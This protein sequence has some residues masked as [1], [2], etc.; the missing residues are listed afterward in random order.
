MIIAN[1]IYDVAFKFLMED[2]ASAKVMLSALLQRKVDKV[3][4]RNQEYS[5]SVSKDL[6]LYRLDFSAYVKNNT[7]TTDVIH[8]ELQKKWLRSEVLRF[9]RYL[10]VQYSDERNISTLPGHEGF[11]LSTV[12]IYIL[13]HA[14]DDLPFPIVYVK[15]QCLDHNSNAC[16][17]ETPSKFVDSISHD[18][19]IVQVPLLASK[20][21]THLE[22]LMSIFHS[23]PEREIE[24]DDKLASSDVEVELV[25]KRLQLVLSDPERRRNL[26]IEQEML[27]DLMDKDDEL[28]KKDEKLREK[29]KMLRDKD[30]ML[31]D[32]DEMLRDRDDA[33]VLKDEKLRQQDN[34]LK[35]QDE[36]MKAQDEKMKEQSDTL[37][38]LVKM[39]VSLGKSDEEI[40]SV[41]H[42]SIS[43]VE[44][45]RSAI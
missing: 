14:L 43:V 32:K 17:L 25:A 20:T 35:I 30:K 8:I 27:A 1:A 12:A 45:I 21:Q 11:G 42:I 24:L 3:E 38:A 22:R 6:S 28:K 34:E 13:G 31:R 2:E 44:Q 9:R 33:I 5:N 26:Q 37:A 10:G 18:A 16:Q 36:K 39:L 7:G 15:R 40:A 19:I 23:S 4:M 41:A 29:D